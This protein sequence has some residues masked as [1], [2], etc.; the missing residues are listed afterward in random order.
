MWRYGCRS[1][2]TPEIGGE[3]GRAEDR[4]SRD[5]PCCQGCR[6]SRRSQNQHSGCARIRSLSNGGER[7]ATSDGHSRRLPLIDPCFRDARDKQAVILLDCSEPTV[8]AYRNTTRIEMVVA[9]L[10]EFLKNPLIR[11]HSIHRPH[12]G[13]THWLTGEASPAALFLGAECVVDIQTTPDAFASSPI[14]IERRRTA[15]MAA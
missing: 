12:S 5:M 8:G 3:D 10:Q 4:D 15:E 1:D 2:Q 13:A 7:R 11:N 14:L 6:S 9:S